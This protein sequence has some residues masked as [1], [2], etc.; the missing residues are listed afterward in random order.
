M[1]FRKVS[2]NE[3]RCSVSVEEIRANGLEVSDLL[4]R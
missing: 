2:E 4:T 1:N 3:L